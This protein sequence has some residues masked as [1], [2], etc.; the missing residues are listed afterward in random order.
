MSSDLLSLLLEKLMA[1]LQQQIQLNYGVL[2]I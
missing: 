1:A 2:L